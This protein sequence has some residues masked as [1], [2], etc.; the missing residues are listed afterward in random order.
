MDDFK[1]RNNWC[2]KK[3]EN[4]RDW[5]TVSIINLAIAL[6]IESNELW[7]NFYGK[8]LKMQIKIN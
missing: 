8:I 1:E 7:N 2:S 5:G 3:F 6:S 4:E